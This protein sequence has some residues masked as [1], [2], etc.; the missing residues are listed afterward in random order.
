MK[1]KEYKIFLEASKIIE[2]QLRKKFPEVRFV[3]RTEKDYVILQIMV[4][5][6]KRRGKGEAKA[7]MK[8]L[9][10]LGKENKQDIYLTPS[11]LYGGDEKRL[12][13]FYRSLGF[14]DNKS[15]IKEKLVYSTK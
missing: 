14:T 11:D 2:I 5:Q 12:E 8:Y 1:F 6:E 9:I 15:N 4:I 3:L 7:F 10:E 13:K